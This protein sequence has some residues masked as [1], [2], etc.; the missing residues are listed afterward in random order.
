MLRS[1]ILGLKGKIDLLLFGELI[2]RKNQITTPV[3]IPMELKSG[4]RVSDAHK[5]QTDIYNILVREKYKHPTMGLLYYSDSDIK[6]FRYE[7]PLYAYEIVIVH[8]NIVAQ[9]LY[10]IY[11]QDSGPTLPPLPESFSQCNY[12]NSSLIC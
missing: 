1:S 4:R 10:A 3:Y 8:R 5:K 12:C 11:L 2:D 6:F 7:E 9:N